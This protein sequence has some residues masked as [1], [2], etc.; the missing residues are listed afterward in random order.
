VCFGSLGAWQPQQLHGLGRLILQLSP[1][2]Q[3]GKEGGGSVGL[4]P[5]SFCEFLHG[6]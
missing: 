1:A 6:V 4:F 3:H 2:G 5:L